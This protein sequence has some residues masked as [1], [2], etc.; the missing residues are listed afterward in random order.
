MMIA[1]KAL[2]RRTVL[3]GLGVT[4]ALPFLDA[5]VPALSALGDAPRRLGFI[6]IPNGVAMNFTGVNYWRPPDPQEPFELSPILA[7]LAPVRDRVLVVSGLGHRQA[8]GAEPVDDGANGDHA[9]GTTTWLTGVRPLH[10]EST[11]VRN[12]I[13][14]DQLAAAVLGRDTTLPSLEL[15]IGINY[16]EGNCG[17]GY[18]CVYLN[19][20]AWRSATTPVPT[21]DNPR[22]VFERLFGHGRVAA[23]RLAD[24][25]QN[26]SILDSVL[27]QT[28]RLQQT[29]GPADRATLDGYL[30]A[31]REVERR[32]QAAETRGGDAARSFER[33]L[34]IPERFDEHVSLMYDMLWIA[35]QAD[36]TRVA[37]FMLGVELNMRTYPEIGITDRHHALSHHGDDPMRIERYSKV[38]IYQTDLF[39]KFVDKLRSTPDG[40]GTL[41]DHSMLLYGAGLSDPNLHTH[42]DLPL[43]LIGRGVK[44]GRHLVYP[45]GT[46]MTNLLVSMLD[47][48][49]V[50]VDELGDSTGPLGGQPLSGV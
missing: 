9:R 7:P 22:V 46:P 36:I 35:F 39:A 1:R 48:S 27:E 3:R 24:A 45:A 10:T 21:E 23:E 28:L 43:S 8:D 30:D 47:R 18:S 34:S 25:R 14:A 13:S 44:G 5:M 19:T 42:F 41:L 11:A 6:Y 50:P 32:L 2:P 40:D 29:L 33:P 49:G 31:T 26:R 16:L 37:T 20:L 17:N 38:N 15:G 4:L 12:G